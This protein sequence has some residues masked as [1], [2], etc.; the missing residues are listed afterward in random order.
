VNGGKAELRGILNAGLYR[1]NAFV[2][3][4]VGDRKQPK[5]CSVWSPKAIA[6]IGR[7]PDTLED[8]SI[9]IPMRRRNP[10][11]HV[12][13]LH[14]VRLFAELE[15]VRRKAVR[16]AMDHLDKLGNITPRLPQGLHDRA[17]DLWRPLLAIAE[18]AGGDWPERARRAATELSGLALHD[19][20]P[21]LQL[22]ASIHAL[23]EKQQTDRLSSETIVC[24]L[25]ETEGAGSNGRYLTQARLARRLSPFGIRPTIGHRTRTHVSRG[26]LL[27]DF[28]DAFARYLNR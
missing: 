3:R 8:R 21:E 24:A 17:Q 9:V 13:L 28:R 26:Y 20:S 18:E 19:N 4:C 27:Q 11:E 23:F 6:L 15:T 2:L 14:V 10:E 25:A 22:L 5:I 1:S 16:W 12:D 7:L